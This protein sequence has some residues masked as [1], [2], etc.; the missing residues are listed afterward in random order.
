MCVSIDFLPLQEMLKRG[1]EESSSLDSAKGNN[2]ILPGQSR[3]LLA[4]SAA[5]AAAVVDLNE[6]V[7]A[8]ETNFD[9]SKTA[10]G[11]K[12]GGGGGGRGGSCGEGEGDDGDVCL[13]A[14]PQSGKR[15]IHESLKELGSEGYIIGED[16]ERCLHLC[17]YVCVCM[18][19]GV[20][21]WVRV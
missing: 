6:V 11:G 17:V 8:V 10:K 7:K 15:K 1:N 2:V 13:M 19:V 4:N 5:N 12:G 9:V 20:W 21:V 16:I 3:N 18:C 14:G